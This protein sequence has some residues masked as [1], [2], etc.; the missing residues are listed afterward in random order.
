M[1]KSKQNKVIEF[2]LF[3]LMVIF[4]FGQLISFRFRFLGMDIPFHPIDIISLLFLIVVVISKPEKPKIFRYLK[5]LFLIALASQVIFIAFNGIN[6]TLK[7]FLY[8]LRLVSYT[9]IFIVVWNL[10][11]NSKS[12]K[13]RIFTYLIGISIFVA[14]FGWYQYFRYPDLTSL[15]FLGWDDH[16]YRLV[17]S[18]FDPTFTSIL[19]VFGILTTF[20]W[21]Q[22]TKKKKY[23]LVLMLLIS[24]LLFT[25]SRAG[26]LALFAGIFT[27]LA[28]K[29]RLR[30]SLLF[31]PLI[32][33]GIILLPKPSSEGTNLVRT[34]SISARLINYIDTAKI[35]TKSPLIGVGYN[36]L[37]WAKVNFLG[38]SDVD[39]HACSGSDSSLLLILATTGIFGFI[40]FINLVIKEIMQINTDVYGII[41]IAS[42][43]SLFV[44]SLFGNSLFYPWVMVYISILGA[45]CQKEV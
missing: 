32:I 21:Y 45:L 17:G 24:S 25:Y 14:L 2:L 35:I 34:A 9:S 43:A 5:D 26:Y 7:G 36:N 6:P 22:V 11:R 39:S 23:I 3:V 19:L 44:H 20:E 18:F 29:K 27:L 8:L 1:V 31:I 10:V 16:L 30:I 38:Q 13:R 4:P 37:C 41:F 28:V 33:V 40:L 12:T 15:K 42:L